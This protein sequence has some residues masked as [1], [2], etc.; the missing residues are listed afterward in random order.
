MS[1]GG[2]F[3]LRTVRTASWSSSGQGEG[4]AAWAEITRPERS[5]VN[6]TTTVPVWPLRREVAG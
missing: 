6:S 4:W 3:H 5:M 2:N 1:P